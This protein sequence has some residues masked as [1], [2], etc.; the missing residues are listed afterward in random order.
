MLVRDLSFGRALREPIT[1]RPAI[2]SISLPLSA[3]DYTA[4]STLL[5]IVAGAMAGAPR[6]NAAWAAGPH[7]ASWTAAGRD[8]LA[9]GRPCPSEHDPP[10]VH[11]KKGTDE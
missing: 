3:P 4:A 10:V 5:R 6:S 2:A 7:A 11:V 1:L 9:A 8:R